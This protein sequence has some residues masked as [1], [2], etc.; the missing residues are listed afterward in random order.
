MKSQTKNGQKGF[1]FQKIK[2]ESDKKKEEIISPLF[3]T[4]KETKCIK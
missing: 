3:L 4:Q 1:F 2:K